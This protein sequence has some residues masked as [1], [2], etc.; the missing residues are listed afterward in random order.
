MNNEGKAFLSFSF[1][2]FTKK[3]NNLII[4]YKFAALK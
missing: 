1:V 2:F 4:C 3:A